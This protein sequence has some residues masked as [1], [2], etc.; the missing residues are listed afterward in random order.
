[1][2]TNT[3]VLIVVAALAVLVLA[4]VLALVVYKTRSEQR[5]GKGETLRDQ[6][7][8][9]ELRTA[10]SRSARRRV[11]CQGPYRPGRGRH[12]D[13]PGRQSAR[14]SDGR[15]EAKQSPPATN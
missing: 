3:M 1:M 8:K 14:A 15:I 13:C 12:Q 7:D 5:H 4:G 10:A 2:A 9:D 11:R 6:A